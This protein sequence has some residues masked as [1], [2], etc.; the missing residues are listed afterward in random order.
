M[1]RRSF[2]LTI[3]ALGF[4][5]AAVG[6]LADRI[7]I[8]ASDDFGEKQILVVGVGIA[9]A[10]VGIIIAILAKKQADGVDTEE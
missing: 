2:G 1:S 8:G 9:I 7:G 10:A 4:I 6:A 3:T 5:V